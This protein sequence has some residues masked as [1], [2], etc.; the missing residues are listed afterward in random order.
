MTVDVVI[1]PKAS[2]DEIVGRHGD[3]IKIKLTAPPVE[4]KANAALIAFLAKKLGIP[5]SA[6]TILRGHASRRK[7]I[8]ITGVTSAD[9]V[10]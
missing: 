7:T 2:R 1:Q 8:A 3:A 6:I 9:L 5:K 4:G 10:V